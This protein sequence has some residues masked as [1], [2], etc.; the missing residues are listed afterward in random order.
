MSIMDT[1]LEL[2]DFPDILA[3]VDEYER[4]Y[5]IQG[6]GHGPSRRDMYAHAHIADTRH[7][8]DGHH[9][10]HRTHPNTRPGP[11]MPMHAPISVADADNPH[12]RMHTE[13]VSFDINILMN[14]DESMSNMA[15]GAGPVY[16]ATLKPDDMLNFMSASEQADN[17]DMSRAIVTQVQVVSVD[18]LTDR[19]WTLNVMDGA[20]RR[21][22]KQ[23]SLFGRKW[24]LYS[25]N[26]FELT[27]VP[28][29]Q[30]SRDSPTIVY[31]R[32]VRFFGLTVFSI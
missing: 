32:Q 28:L 31:E 11:S 17:K 1:R 2:D 9:P 7:S 16:T 29:C 18:G 30:L 24:G 22:Q 14:L 25:D 21:S 3:H 19:R 4:A 15:S 10:H 20:P 26:T 13:P 8:S 5:G 12:E 6:D 23:K 27:G